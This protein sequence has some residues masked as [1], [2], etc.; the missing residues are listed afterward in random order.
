M[1]RYL[2]YSFGASLWFTLVFYVSWRMTFPAD[3]ASQY[4]AYRLSEATA[5]AYK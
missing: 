5:D 4:V 1:I 2:G 3:E